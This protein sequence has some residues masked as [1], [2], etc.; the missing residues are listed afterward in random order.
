[1]RLQSPTVYATIQK[2]VDVVIVVV[3][4]VVRTSSAPTARLGSILLDEV[5]ID[6]LRTT[7]LCH[8]ELR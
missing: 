6:Q 8:T 2:L 5:R 7:L 4:P 3:R 1:M